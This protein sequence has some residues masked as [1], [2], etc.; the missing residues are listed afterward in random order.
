MTNIRE[1][2][3]HPILM[4][5][6]SRYYSEDAYSAAAEPKELVI[7]SGADHVDL[8]DNME[9]IPFDK[10]EMFFKENLK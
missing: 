4:I 3:Q 7:V 5:A 6:H 10:L 9:K 2:S 8:Y 1:V